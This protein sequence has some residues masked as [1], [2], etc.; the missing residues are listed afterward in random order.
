VVIA[1]FSHLLFLSQFY[2]HLDD[3]IVV[4]PLTRG[5]AEWLARDFGVKLRNQ[6]LLLNRKGGVSMP[7]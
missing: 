7:P 1:F 4:T 5:S 2:G 6:P 3:G